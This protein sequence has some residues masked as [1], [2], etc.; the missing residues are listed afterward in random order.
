MWKKAREEAGLPVLPVRCVE[1]SGQEALEDA[2]DVVVVATPPDLQEKIAAEVVE[3]RMALFLE[4]PGGL[5]A[6]SLRRLAVR[7]REQ[8]MPAVIDFVMRY[9][10]LV[11]AL[12]KIVQG[13][14][15]GLPE[16]VQMENWAGGQLPAGHWFWDPGRSGGILVEHGVH[17]FDMVRN[18]LGGEWAPVHAKIWRTVRPGG[19]TAEDRVLAVVEHRGTSDSNGKGGTW[20]APASYYH[21]F[22]RPGDGERTQTGFVFSGGYALLHSWIPERLELWLDQGAEIDPLDPEIFGENPH[23]ERSG[24]RLVVAY[25]DRQALY[26]QAVRSCMTDL[27]AA[28]R[29]PRHA[30]EA[31]LEDGAR[32]L[33]LAN[34]LTDIARAHHTVA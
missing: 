20:R 11:K 2:V 32:A 27:L 17:F 16:H 5:R 6:E 10:P 1:G 13:G 30:V 7:A 18:I 25:P 8:G 15:L 28:R 22:T 4:K 9:N 12:R 3:R 26:R 19:W 31:S 21:G 33:D 14:I 23:I 29:D 24:R 34:K